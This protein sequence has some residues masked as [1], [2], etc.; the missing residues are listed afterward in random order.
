MA[1]VFADRWG[2]ASPL[3][4]LAALVWL[5]GLAVA[6]AQQLPVHIY[7]GEA[8]V[9]GVPPPDGTTVSAWI[10]GQMI[11]KS[12]VEDGRYTLKAERSPERFYEGKT[13]T[14][15]VGGIQTGQSGSWVPGG[16]T[17]VDLIA[18]VHQSQSQ[19]NSP[20]GLITRG[21]LTN[22]TSGEVSGADRFMDPTALA[23][24]GMLLPLAVTSVSLVRV[25]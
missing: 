25:S 8:V 4:L 7:A 21:F 22:S 9:D 16:V 19:E 6:H 5:S 12:T 18:K 24:L 3:I 23:V 20:R 2:L 1:T 14:Y 17:T 15:K 11:A 10:D 13:V